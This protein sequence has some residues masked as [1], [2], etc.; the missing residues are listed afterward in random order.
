MIDRL[1]SAAA[2]RRSVGRKAREVPSLDLNQGLRTPEHL[3]TAIN[4]LFKPFGGF[5]LPDMTREPLREPPTFD[6]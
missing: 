3:G 4:T 5:E 1:P 6:E 2:H